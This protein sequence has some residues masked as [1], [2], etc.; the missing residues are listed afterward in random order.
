MELLEPD[1][2]QPRPEL[3][4]VLNMCRRIELRDIETRSDAVTQVLQSLR[5]SHC[6]GGAMF[7][8]VSIGADR[9]FDWYASRNRLL[10][11]DI[12]PRILRREETKA[13]LKELNIGA[14]SNTSKE[15]EACSTSSTDGFRMDN[16]FLFEGQLAACLHSGGAYTHPSGDGRDAKQLALNFCDALFQHRFADLSLSTSYAA[17]KPW[18][19]EIAWDWT[20]VLFDRQKRLLHILTVTDTD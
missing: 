7:A 8:T 19:H 1:W 5:E 16:A 4:E 9:V 11:W 13:I 3:T 18:F 6:N 20:A 10:E 15:G 17:W 2:N 12:L 14:L